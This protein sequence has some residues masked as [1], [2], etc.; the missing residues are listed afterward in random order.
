MTDKKRVLVVEDN[1]MNLTLVADLLD[2]NGFE[3]LSAE[4]GYKALDVINSEK[5]DLVLLD[6]Q[7][8]DIDGFEVF[9]KV[10]EKSNVSNMKVVALT[11]QAMK[12]DAD[13]IRDAGFK[14]YITK[15]IETRE[16]IGQI[17]EILES[18]G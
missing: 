5:L 8:P 11:A 6:I 18:A 3:V 15:P 17:M 14:W 13:R 2:F 1:P 16:F 4:D 7:L 10:R 9:R 12:D